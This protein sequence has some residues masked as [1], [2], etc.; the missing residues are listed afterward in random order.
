M[1][2]I[3]IVGLKARKHSCHAGFTLLSDTDDVRVYGDSDVQVRLFGGVA[4][5]G[6]LHDPPDDYREYQDPSFERKKMSAFEDLVCNKWGDYVALSYDRQR[7]SLEV[8]RS[9]SG[10]L[11]CYYIGVADGVVIGSD[12]E[13]VFRCAEA[14][15]VI[16]WDAVTLQLLRR[17][18][19]GQNCALEG[20]REVP[21]G[22]RVHIEGGVCRKETLWS[23]ARHVRQ[24]RRLTLEKAA[25]RLRHTAD[26]C[27]NASTNSSGR[28]LLGVSGGLDSSIVA[29]CLAR[30]GADFVCFSMFD[31]GSD[32]DERYHARSLSD[33][34]G[35]KLVECPYRLEGI[36]LETSSV[37]ALPRPI[38]WPFQQALDAACM[39]MMDR[40]EAD[41]IARGTGGDAVFCYNNS[42]APIADAFIEDGAR[43]AGRTLLDLSTLTGS[44]IWQCLAAAY[45]TTRNKGRPS[46]RMDG[47][48][49]TG[50][51]QQHPLTDFIHPWLEES[52][53]LPPGR[54]RHIDMLSVSQNFIETRRALTRDVLCPL[55]SQP[56]V[57]LALTVATPDWIRGGVNRAVARRA[58][59]PDLP[60]AI[61]QR[62]TKGGP[63]SFAAALYRENRRQI[64]EILLDGRLTGRHILDRPAIETIT[65]DSGGDVPR[66]F[67]RLLALVDAEAWI[68]HWT[69]VAGR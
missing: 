53:D 69:T 38:G 22:V 68:S 48:F 59:A 17:E 52:S 51:A 45:R 21:A 34:L 14:P 54:Q 25:D 64:R 62:T 11:P 39:A 36:D 58:F 24:N 19:R 30:A 28:I 12:A 4:V 65:S 41:V 43:A 2:F 13:Q 63:T 55:L 27:V 66:E 47:S 42:A 60:A 3:A 61:I 15:V 8:F 67:L 18:W 20:L 26:H 44:S 16:D 40:E 56:I 50:F 33:H 49:M 32:G 6:T 37:A 7:T 31:E 5:I 23:P 29:A 57:E 35:V 46:R 1:R 10:M 9:P